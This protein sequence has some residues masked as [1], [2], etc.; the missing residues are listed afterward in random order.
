MNRAC[1]P[2]MH[3]SFAPAA[4]I[5]QPE[6]VRCAL[7]GTTMGGLIAEGWDNGAQPNGGRFIVILRKDSTGYA[8][9]TAAISGA[10]NGRLN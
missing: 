6:E 3:P 4:A 8:C 9:K 7:E 5:A 2:A 1:L 10:P